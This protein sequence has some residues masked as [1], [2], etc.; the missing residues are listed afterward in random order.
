MTYETATNVF[1]GACIVFAVAVCV[2]CG[3]ISFR[4]MKEDAKD[5]STAPPESEQEQPDLSLLVGA[6]PLSETPF[7]RLLAVRQ[8]QAAREAQW[9]SN[10]TQ[11]LN[12][13]RTQLGLLR[14]APP[15]AAILRDREL[16]E[17]GIMDAERC[18][19]YLRARAEGASPEVVSKA[20]AAFLKGRTL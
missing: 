16:I 15:T 20:C 6:A 4:A 12:E 13:L 5:A 2:I 9:M 8:E 1:A 19:K 3:A 11:C 18:L 14:A 17:N 7:V 10:I